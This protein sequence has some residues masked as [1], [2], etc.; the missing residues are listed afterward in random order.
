MFH[1]LNKD[2]KSF[3]LEWIKRQ[4]AFQPLTISH[5]CK[6]LIMRRRMHTITP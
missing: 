6:S 5:P 1:K 2:V 3:K 4:F